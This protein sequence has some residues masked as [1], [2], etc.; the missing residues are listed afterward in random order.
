MK[1]GCSC[2]FVPS[3]TIG[4]GIGLDGILPTVDLIWTRGFPLLVGDIC[5]SHGCTKCNQM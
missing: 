2:L 5:N 1:F 3:Q 4:L